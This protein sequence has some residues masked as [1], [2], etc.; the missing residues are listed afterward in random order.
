MMRRPGLYYL[1]DTPTSYRLGVFHCIAEA[2]PGRFRVAFCAGSEPGRAHDLDFTGLNVDVLDGIRWQPPW[3]INPHAFK[4]NPGVIGA[5]ERFE[6]QVVVLAGYAQPTMI[7]AARWCIARGIPYAI[8]CETSRRSTATRGARWLLRR[9][10]IGWMIRNM[11]FGLPTGRAAAAYL[12]GLGPSRAPMQAFP[13]TPDTA[14]YR[15]TVAEFERAGGACEIR[16][17]YGLPADGPVFTFVGRLV[18]A[19]RPQD[20]VR[21]F[22]LLPS[23][24]AA[25]LLIVGDGPEMGRLRG[26]ANGDDRIVFAGWI[27]DSREL[28]RVLATSS[29]LVLPSAHE[30]WGAVVNEA[31]ASKVCPIVTDCVGAAEELV[32]HARNG[33]IV[34]VADVASFRDAMLTLIRDPA[35]CRAMGDAAQ[36]TAIRYGVGFAAENLVA[37]AI[38]ALAV[39]NDE[40]A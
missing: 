12:H 23:E 34:P 36:A 7:R 40:T 4:W 27:R 5:L 31:M 37:G 6:P 10:A 11:A 13:N 30:P 15:R 16:A 21:A 22:R 9:R 33:F 29:A 3:Q 26:E 35:R 24:I 1:D 25:S 14:L 18:A 8:T 19:K 28:A 38:E 20:A 32:E 17:R 39:P 2:W